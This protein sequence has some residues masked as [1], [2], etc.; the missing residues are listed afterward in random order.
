METQGSSL[1]RK[2]ARKE[3]CDEEVRSER[4]FRKIS[5]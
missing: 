3:N 4:L 2:E 1:F 5:F